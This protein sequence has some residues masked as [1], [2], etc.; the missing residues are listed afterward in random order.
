MAWQR[1]TPQ[2]R[3]EWQTQTRRA[4]AARLDLAKRTTWPTTCPHCGR[5]LGPFDEWECGH[6]KPRRLY[7]GLMWDPDNH[8]V[9]CRD[10]NRSEGGRL[11]QA[12]ASGRVTPPPR[13][14]RA[15]SHL[16][17]TGPAKV[18]PSEGRPIPAPLTAPGVSLGVAPPSK[19]PAPRHKKA[20][21]PDSQPAFPVEPQMHRDGFPLPRISPQLPP[22]VDLSIGRQAVEW[23]D[24]NAPGPPLMPWQR[25]VVELA[26]ATVPDKRSKL[27]WSL[28]FDTVVLRLARQQGKTF[29]ARR[30]LLWRLM[31]GT[32][33]FG[34]PQ[35]I[36]NTHPDAVQAVRLMEPV[37][38]QL[39]YG[40]GGLPGLSAQ[41]FMAE[42]YPDGVED[43]HAPAWFARA[44]TTSA[45][46]G[47]QGITAAYVDEMQDASQRLVQEALGGAL[48]GARVVAQQ[49]WFTGTGAKPGSDLLRGMRRR[50][51]GRG[52]CWIEW[53]APP[54]CD[55][56]DPRVWRWASPDWSDGREAYLR[57]QLEEVGEETFVSNYLLSDDDSQRQQPG[58]EFV[59]AEVWDALVGPCPDGAPAAVAV[60]S[61]FGDDLVVAAAW[62]S[63]SGV[64]VRV[65]AAGSL[66]EAR[67]V[68]DSLGGGRLL[69]G[70]QHASH[71][72]WLGLVVEPL[73]L[74]SLPAVLGLASLAVSGEVGHD[75]GRLLGEQLAAAR[76]AE[77]DGVNG[78]RLLPGARSHAVRAAWAACRAALEPQQQGWFSAGGGRG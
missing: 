20:G 21:F 18:D 44:L 62:P 49:R 3:D 58:V 10:C 7:P 45:L 68:V 39:G 51:G 70:K 8:R 28:L 37:A 71:V 13:L 36:I 22:D 42:W 65:V 63:V 32:R 11:G 35:R 31:E 48:S 54:G 26:L 67:S 2:Q 30:F 27:G 16:G 14:E 56:E 52:M 59:G 23:I 41:T 57:G 6:I 69:V 19:Q 40:R 64:W 72:V 5:T 74:A 43:E 76:R 46:T 33:L 61:W 53:S 78:P 29:L 60:D 25:L 55:V 9:E 38:R 75:G 77:V 15:T 12:I 17:A 24:T 34:Q 66:D 50:L 4:R 73:T 1:Q 47:N